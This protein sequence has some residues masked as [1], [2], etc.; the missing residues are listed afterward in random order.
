MIIV[1]L[2]LSTSRHLHF[3]IVWL[4]TILT[5]HGPALKKASSQVM[6]TLNGIISA[7]ASQTKALSSICDS[8]QFSLD[9]ILTMGKLNAS[10]KEISEEI[11]VF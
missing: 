1:Y 11:E 9:V 8:N 10:E 7:L 6:S 3:Y 4:N 5:T 2:Q